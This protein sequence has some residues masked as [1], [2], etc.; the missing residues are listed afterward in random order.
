[1]N[2]SLCPAHL[3]IYHTLKSLVQEHEMAEEGFSRIASKG[4]KFTKIQEW[5]R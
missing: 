1:M 5:V 4:T 2:S 3:H